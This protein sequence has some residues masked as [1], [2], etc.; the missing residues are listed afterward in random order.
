M[1]LGGQKILSQ[2]AKLTKPEY[3]RRAEEIK[4]ALATEVGGWTGRDATK[5]AK[6]ERLERCKADP[7]EFGRTYLPHYYSDEPAPFHFELIDLIQARSTEV[8]PVVVAAPRGFAKS[9]TVSFGYVLHQI[10]FGLRHFIVLGSDTADLASDLTAYLHLE[11]LYNERIRADFGSQARESQAVDDF[12]T[13]KGVR[14]LARGIGQRVRGIKHGQHRPDLVILD[15]LENDKNVKNP[16]LIEALLKWILETV[17][18]AI[19]PKGSLFIVGTLLDKR[20][21]LAKMVQGKDEPFCHWTRRL[22]RAIQADGTS[23]WPSRHPIDALLRQK[24]FMGTNAFNKEKQNDPKDD[25]GMFQEDWIKE[26]T[27]ADL[28]PILSRLIV[29]GWYDP[30]ARDSETH[31]Y[32]AVITVGLDPVTTLVYVLDAFIRKCSIDHSI[33]ICG[34]RHLSWIYQRFGLEDNGFQAHLLN[35]F[36]R[37]AKEDKI[38]VPVCG[39]TSDIAKSARV[40]SLSP[41]IENGRILFRRGHSDQDLLIEQLIYYPSSTVNDDGPDALEGAF[42]LTQM[43]AGLEFEYQTVQRRRMASMR[44]AW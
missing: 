44:G 9:T 1:S 25:N 38:V 11:L 6:K 28:E 10:L 39:Y 19:D 12:V 24:K 21:A 17:Y 34:A 16:K 27:E 42:R 3:K 29:V 15:D 26:Y 37:M 40:G 43:F 5:E 35:D 32:K 18:S 4:R 33:K 23:L 13:T 41:H 36:A 7:F 2:A 20:S 14:L 30:S 22:Y 8:V 31:D